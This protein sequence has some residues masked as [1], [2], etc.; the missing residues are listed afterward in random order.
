MADHRAVG[1]AAVDAARDAGNRWV[2]PELV[3]EGWEP[4]GGVRRAFVNASP[5]ARHWVD[6][7]D[8]IDRGIASLRAHRAYL[9]GLGDGGMSDPDA[10]LRG[11][12][13]QAGQDAGT[14]YAVPFEVIDL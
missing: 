3:Q 8:T 4:W 1:R 2:F 10:F 14:V 12:A 7:S 6:V 13:A 11:H 9:A 5:D